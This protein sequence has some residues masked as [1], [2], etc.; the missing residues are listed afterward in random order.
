MKIL[1]A[2]PGLGK[3]TFAEVARRAGARVDDTDELLLEQRAVPFTT[4]HPSEFQDLS[5]AD[6]A[7]VSTAVL[8]LALSR[9]TDILVTNLPT[10]LPWRDTVVVIM[11]P[12]DYK[13]HWLSEEMFSR[14]TEFRKREGSRALSMLGAWA[15][16]AVRNTRGNRRF[17][18][19]PG[20]FIAQNDQVMRALGFSCAMDTPN[21]SR[22]VTRH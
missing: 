4:R 3:T 8:N 11:T 22:R 12:A 9:E 20:S 16:S 13:L 17:F 5:N 18:L 19:R 10:L 7:V 6:R 15:S 2:L 21:T 14:L 1:Y